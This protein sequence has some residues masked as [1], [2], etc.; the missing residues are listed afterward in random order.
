[1]PTGSIVAYATAPGDTADD[2]K[3]TNGVYTEQLA[4]QLSQPGLDLREV[5]D[6]TA[7]EVER[8][9]SGKQKPREDV[10]LRGRFVLKPGPGVQTASLSPE[11]TG[12]P[13]QSDPEE[14]AW[15]AAKSANT[16]AAFEAYLGEY[17]KGRY[18]SAARVAK[19]AAQGQTTSQVA[20]AQA[21]Q[22]IPATTSSIAAAAQITKDCADCP[23]M[24][25]IPAGSF[26]M[27]G[28][29]EREKP[30]HS[31]NIRSFAMGKTQVT[32]GQWEAVMG[33]NPS[34]F[35]KCGANCPVEKVSWD[36]A[37]VF[38]QKLNAKTGKQY[39]LPSEAEWEYACRAGGRHE[40]CGSDNADAVGWYGAN[41]GNTTHPV[42]GK[43]A[44]AFGLYDMSGNVWQWVEDYHHDSYSGAPTD[45]SVWTTGG[46]Q[47]FRVLRGGSWYDRPALLRSAIRDGS[48]P[49]SGNSN[50]GFR[51]ART[52]FTP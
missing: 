33:N 23:E 5:F 2:G 17:P 1:V 3:G 20:P 22:R 42:A 39:R 47:K 25:V 11:P 4:R 52:L 35:P 34:N 28:G 40:Y 46:E 45:G 29:A 8:I 36:D 49:F 18:A 44:N 37:Q 51:L 43:E 13:V 9:T 31:V 27:G 21:P 48:S 6:R 50:Y 16:A 15:Q 12:R 24:V 14:E 10:G 7:T 30:V 41:S 32:Q 38:I 26:E 19:S